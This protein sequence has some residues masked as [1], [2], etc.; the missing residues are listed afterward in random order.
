M[1]FFAEL[2]SAL[3]HT[4]LSETSSLMQEAVNTT[5]PRTGEKPLQL[6]G[7]KGLTAHVRRQKAHGT[8]GAEKP[9]KP[10]FLQREASAS[11]KPSNDVDNGIVGFGTTEA[12]PYASMLITQFG[13]DEFDSGSCLAFAPSHRS[14]SAG[15]VT[16]RDWQVPSPDSADFVKLEPWAVPCDNQW[17]KDNPSKW[18]GYSFYT[19]E[20]VIEKCAAITYSMSAQPVISFVGGLE[21]DILPAPLI[22]ITTEVCWPDRVTAPDLS[23]MVYFTTGHFKESVERPRNYFGKGE[24]NDDDKALQVLSR[25]ALTQSN[26]SRAEKSSK[27][28]KIHQDFEVKQEKL[29]L[30]S[31]KYDH[32]LGLNITARSSANERRLY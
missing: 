20:S 6:T 19:Y 5:F 18:E 4:L 25:A 17:A 30:A 9:E 32:K 3:I 28:S 27:T 8:S 1:A 23:L 16:K 22:E 14:G 10:S 31:A 15:N 24:A 2:A 7:P 29:F 12:Q 26:A 11:R 21:F 13:G